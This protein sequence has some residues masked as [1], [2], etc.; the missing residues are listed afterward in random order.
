MEFECCFCGKNIESS[1]INPCIISIL[2]N[3]DK[4]KER[5]YSQDF[6]C[7]ITCFKE[8]IASHIPLYVEHLGI[9]ENF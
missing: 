9:E 5:Q 3:F 8:K 4:S 6:F 2:T 1:K 7:H